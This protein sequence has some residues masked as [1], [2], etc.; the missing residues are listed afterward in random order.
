MRL[1]AFNRI[2]FSSTL[3]S[4]PLHIKGQGKK[5]QYLVA[6]PELVNIPKE[7]PNKGGQVEAAILRAVARDR[8]GLAGLSLSGFKI[9]A[10][11]LCTNDTP[12]RTGAAG[13]CRIPE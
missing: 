12:L 5:V 2:R 8:R 11:S 7:E 3:L 10:C 9:F 4:Q 13:T 6:L 1:A